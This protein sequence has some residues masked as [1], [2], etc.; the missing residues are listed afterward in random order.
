MA[1]VNLTIGALAKATGTKTQTIRYYEHVGLLPAPDRTSGNYRSYGSDHLRP[2]SFIRSRDLGFSID[3]FRGLLSLADWRDADCGV[4]DEI[5]RKH[6]AEIERKI[7]DLEALR[8]ELKDLIGQCGN[9][10]I[11]ECRIIEALSPL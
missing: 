10:T 5:A 9:G 3:A 6:L 7:T 1:D 8:H 11:A 2:L 4:V